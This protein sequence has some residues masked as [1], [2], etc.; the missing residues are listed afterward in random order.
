MAKFEEANNRIF[1]NKFVCK[2][3]K[4]T[5]KAPNIAVLQG[6]IKCRAC[7]SRALRVKRKK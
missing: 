3:C 4:S 6:K 7:S 5:I 1:K 2:R